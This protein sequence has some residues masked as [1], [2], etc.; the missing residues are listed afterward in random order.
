[1]QALAHYERAASLCKEQMDVHRESRALCQQMEPYV[2][3]F[4]SGLA[5]TPYHVAGFCQH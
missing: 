5:K 3:Q 1:M 2:S 4:C